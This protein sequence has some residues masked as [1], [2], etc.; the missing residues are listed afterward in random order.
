M[1]NIMDKIT[2]EQ[3]MAYERVRQSGVTNMLD[4]RRVS[5]LSNLGRMTIHVIMKNYEKLTEKFNKA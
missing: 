1:F 5:K 2:E 4:T 3:F